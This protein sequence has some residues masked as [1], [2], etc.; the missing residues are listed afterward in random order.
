MTRGKGDEGSRGTHTSGK[1]TNDETVR[2]GGLLNRK[3]RS[4]AALEGGD[5]RRRR[6]G[7]QKKAATNRRLETQGGISP[8]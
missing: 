1:P 5:E 2:P 3:E 7:K 8:V 4:N 6:G